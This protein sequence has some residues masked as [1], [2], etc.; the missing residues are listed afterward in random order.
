MTCGPGKRRWGE[1]G[2]V[3]TFYDRESK[4]FSF[5]CHIICRDGFERTV[6][7]P[8]SVPTSGTRVII[9]E[10][11]CSSIS[12]DLNFFCHKN[13]QAPNPLE[14]CSRLVWNGVV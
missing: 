7:V 6:I 10:Q 2:R 8:Y 3:T 4:E 14:W 11:V 9:R 12:L 1:G 5:S 13:V